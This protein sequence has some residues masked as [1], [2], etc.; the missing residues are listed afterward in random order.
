MSV[1]GMLLENLNKF[2]YLL[3]IFYKCWKIVI[4]STK[5]KIICKEIKEVL[6][7]FA[8]ANSYS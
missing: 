4:V 6:P 7:Q 3:N 8:F 2:C 1:M 5:N